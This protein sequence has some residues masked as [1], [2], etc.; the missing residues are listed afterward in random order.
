MDVLPGIPNVTEILVRLGEVSKVFSGENG[1]IAILSGLVGGFF[2]LQSAYRAYHMAQPHGGGQQGGIER[3]LVPLFFGVILINFWQAQQQIS[4][5]FAL[6][7]GVLSPV[8]P[9]QYLQQ[10]W[11]ALRVV[12][13]GFGTIMVFR[14]FLLAKSLGDGVH[15]GQ[16]NPAWG[17]FWHVMGGILLMKL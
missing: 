3:I 7:G 2:I 8:M 10:M 1:L 6:S 16:Q 14:G 15:G 13:N 11:D 17:A 4:E 5:Q 9:S 12:L